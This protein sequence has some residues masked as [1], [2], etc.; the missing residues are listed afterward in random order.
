MYLCLLILSLNNKSDMTATTSRTVASLK[1][2]ETGVILS[3]SNDKVAC[4]LLSMGV[5]PGKTLRLIR[6]APFGGGFYLKVEEHILAIRESEASNILIVE[7][8]E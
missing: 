1:E 5:L 2:G 6:K 7:I 4:K 3:Y 8:E